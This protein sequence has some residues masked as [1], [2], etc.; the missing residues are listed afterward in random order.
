MIDA[1]WVKYTH[2][3]NKLGIHTGSTP[4]LTTK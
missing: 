1:N 2:N 4:V 3:P